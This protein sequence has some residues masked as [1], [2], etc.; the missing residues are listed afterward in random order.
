VEV[1]DALRV[2]AVSVA[3][4]DGDVEFDV[5][6]GRPALALR[7]RRVEEDA[8]RDLRLVGRVPVEN[9]AA[10][11]DVAVASVSRVRGRAE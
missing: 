3:V 4:A 10:D 5:G 1:P 2:D 11:P 9:A 6:V 7:P 8:Q